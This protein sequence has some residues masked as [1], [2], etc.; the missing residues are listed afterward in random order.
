MRHKITF[1]LQ[2][3]LHQSVGVDTGEDWCQETLGIQ[4]EK[5]D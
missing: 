4:E 1:S 5:E 3:A 2:G